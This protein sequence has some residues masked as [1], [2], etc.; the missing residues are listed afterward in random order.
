MFGAGGTQEAKEDAY[1]FLV[2]SPDLCIGKASKSFIV[3]SVSKW[4]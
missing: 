2:H 1:T 3:V 4:N